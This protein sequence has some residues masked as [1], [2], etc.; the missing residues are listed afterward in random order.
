MQLATILA[1]ENLKLRV[2][3]RRQRQKRQQRRQYI[4][5]GGV[6]QTQE[7]QARVTEA[8]RSV[9]EGGQGGTAHARTRAPPTCSNCHEQ[10]HRRTQCRAI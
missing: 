3:S 8:E 9:Q 7:G 5:Q 1:E 10:G 6:L 4:A 2:S